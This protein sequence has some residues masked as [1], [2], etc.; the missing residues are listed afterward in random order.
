MFVSHVQSPLQNTYRHLPA[1]VGASLPS[2]RLPA[3][4]QGGQSSSWHAAT[5]DPQDAN[6]A[7][8]L[9]A[10]G[11][12]RAALPPDPQASGAVNFPR[13]DSNRYLHS[14]ALKGWLME[15][16]DHAPKPKPHAAPRPS[17]PGRGRTPHPVSPQLTAR[18]RN[19]PPATSRPTGPDLP[20]DSMIIAPK[21]SEDPQFLVKDAS[22]PQ[23]PAAAL[24]QQPAA[25]P[26]QAP[27]QLAPQAAQP[28]A[29][30]GQ[31]VVPAVQP[32][33]TAAPSLV[34]AVQPQV[35]S[36]LQSPLLQSQSPALQSVG[37]LRLGPDSSLQ[38]ALTSAMA[39][40]AAPVVQRQ[41]SPSAAPVVQRQPS[42][43]AAPVVQRQPSPGAAHV[44]QRQQSPI[45]GASSGVDNPMIIVPDRM[46]QGLGH[47]SV[48][49]QRSSSR[50]PVG[51]NR[52]SSFATNGQSGTVIRQ[53]SVQSSPRLQPADRVVRQSSATPGQLGLAGVPGPGVRREL[54][55]G[56]GPQREVSVHRRASGS[57]PPA[58]LVVVATVHGAD[59]AQ[60]QVAPAPPAVSARSAVGAPAVVPGTATPTMAA[61][62]Q[63]TIGLAIMSPRQQSSMRHLQSSCSTAAFVSIGLSPQQAHRT[64]NGVS[65]FRPVGR[66]GLYSPPHPCPHPAVR[67][68]AHSPQHPDV[69]ANPHENIHLSP[70]PSVPDLGGQHLLTSYSRPTAAH[71]HGAVTPSMA[72]NARPLWADRLQASPVAESELPSPQSQRREGMTQSQGSLVYHPSQSSLL[73]PQT[74]TRTLRPIQ[75]LGRSPESQPSL[76]QALHGIS[77]ISRIRIQRP[78]GDSGA[79]TA[80]D[81]LPVPQQQLQ[82]ESSTQ[83]APP[84][85][86]RRSDGIPMGP[87]TARIDMLRSRSSLTRVG[88]RESAGSGQGQLLQGRGEARPTIMRVPGV[89]GAAATPSRPI[90]LHAPI[91]VS[92]PEQWSR[93][94]PPSRSRRSSAPL[95]QAPS[96]TS[97]PP[98]VRQLQSQV[99][100]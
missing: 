48:S 45:P 52:S 83:E 37:R 18:S 36:Q 15:Q 54:S 78:P 86:Q 38:A 87:L 16:G 70:T 69:Q 72:S 93:T 90:A 42:P 7:A 59:A 28:A 76:A 17:E 24:A 34:P 58:P 14:K 77:E 84:R 9:N 89:P 62:P 79:L 27:P 6:V 25:Q 1:F 97:D 4:G 46:L 12:V 26:R 20:E 82:R 96:F 64:V 8:R 29:Q 57:L 67:H 53:P 39:A 85:L 68:G 5:A 63:P 11:V 94:A 32:L 50:Q 91:A 44:V 31:L 41:S 92:P 23:Q 71:G 49:R 51:V 100:A 10:A 43:G 73:T 33:M 98:A 22:R 30:V 95:Q 3:G 88:A 55:A 81:P 61:P 47:N 56:P 74:S 99:P 2:P 35:P 40:R 75:R 21:S 66:P 60:V 19:S 13:T 80:R 65:V